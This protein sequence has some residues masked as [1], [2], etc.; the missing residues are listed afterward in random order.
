M[1]NRLYHISNIINLGITLFFF[2]N[3]L[4]SNKCGT[5]EHTQATCE[6]SQMRMFRMIRYLGFLFQVHA[7]D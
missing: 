2:K 5:Y 6:C 4:S 7:I 1:I 3:G